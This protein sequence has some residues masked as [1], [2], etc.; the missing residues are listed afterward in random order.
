MP[1]YFIDTTDG[2]L[3]VD[4]DE[5]VELSGDDDAFAKAL[6]G[7][8]DMTRFALTDGEPSATPR[9]FK[10]QVRSASGEIIF[11]ARVVFQSERKAL[12]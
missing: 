6:H 3:D 11:S 2:R 12:P 1:L 10:V 5:G 9:A 7:L 4:D 8:A